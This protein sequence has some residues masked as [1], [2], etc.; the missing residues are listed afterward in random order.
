VANRFWTSR[1]LTTDSP[2]SP[3]TVPRS[4][5]ILRTLI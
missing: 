3:R 4:G 1:S 5:Q 2:V